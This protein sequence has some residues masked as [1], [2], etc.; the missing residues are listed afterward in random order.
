METLVQKPSFADIAFYVEGHPEAGQVC[1]D[2]GELDA[3][4]AGEPSNVWFFLK[5]DDNERIQWANEVLSAPDSSPYLRKCAA[6]A[7]FFLI[8]TTADEAHIITRRLSELFDVLGTHD[9]QVG[10]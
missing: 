7:V 8:R 5:A 10:L 4:R 2:Q 1:G 3:F 9:I 6:N